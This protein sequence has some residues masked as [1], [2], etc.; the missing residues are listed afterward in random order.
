M[1]I[2]EF[3]NR[4]V[5]EIV[6]LNILSWSCTLRTS[7]KL[8]S[9]LEEEDVVAGVWIRTRGRMLTHVEGILRVWLIGT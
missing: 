6:L 3:E 5:E 7:S 9:I 8:H 2:G 1:E 4:V